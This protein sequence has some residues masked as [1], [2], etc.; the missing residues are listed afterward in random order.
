MDVVSKFGQLGSTQ[1]GDRMLAIVF[2][3]LFY[4]DITVSVSFSRHLDCGQCNTVSFLL[5]GLGVG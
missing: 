3:S 1:L 4:P 5:R 2:V